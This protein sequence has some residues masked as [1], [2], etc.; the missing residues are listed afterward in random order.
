VSGGLD[1]GTDPALLERLVGRCRRATGRPLI[2][3]LTPNVTRIADTARAAERGGADILSLVNT[4]VGLAVDWRH[5]RPELG[6]ATGEGGLS[7]PAIKPLALAAL[8]R[9][10]AATSLPLIG[11]G[12]IFSVDDTMEFLVCG[13]S[14]IQLG[15]A[16][17][18][19][20]SAAI[21]IVQGLEQLVRTERLGALTDW[22][23]SLKAPR[24]TY[25]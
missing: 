8:R 4:F 11:I 22:I 5:R 15:T 25:S 23:G 17:F 21:A 3:K 13:A 6:S 18:R 24:P 10:R 7:G 14:A 2:V 9:V 1:F 20:P 16:N 19:D 12:G